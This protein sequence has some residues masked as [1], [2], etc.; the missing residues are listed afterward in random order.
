M[1]DLNKGDTATPVEQTSVSKT[2]V[3]QKST[4]VNT[5]NTEPE[6]IQQP[7][8]ITYTRDEIEQFMNK[9]SWK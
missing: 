8:E 7:K 5:L 2:E 4:E 6:P 1:K 3:Q 9:Y